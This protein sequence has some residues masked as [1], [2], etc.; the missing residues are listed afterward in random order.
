VSTPN[1][2]IA[3]T[4]DKGTVLPGGNYTSTIVV[5]NAGTA[6]AKNVVI[7]DL[8]GLNT[9]GNVWAIYMSSSS[10]GTAGTLVNHT[11]TA[12]S[13]VDI[14]AGASITF[15]VVSQIP[16]GAAPGNYCDTA[17]FTSDNAGTKDATACVAVPVSVSF[18]VQF[19]DL[20]DGQPAGNNITY[21]SVLYIEPLSNE[22]V[23]NNTMRYSF[24]L[25]STTG[26]GTVPGLFTTLVSTNIYHDPTPIV[27]QI[28]GAIV[29]DRT[30]A[31]AVHLTEGTNYTL[32]NSTPG[33]QVITMTPGYILAPKGVFFIVQVVQAPAGSG[34][35]TPYHTG[36]LWDSVGTVGSTHYEVLKT[37]PTTITQ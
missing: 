33:F 24:G 1:L 6:T 13:T 23:N 21:S 2:T 20:G 5:T 17:T 31:S 29:T 7:S 27:D 34:R 3:K 19:T 9:T 14:A 37:E 28:T 30:N 35:S 18:Q 32:D 26:F 15:T 11:V 12:P 8:L 16:A 25:P 10:S 22:G 4:V 36:F